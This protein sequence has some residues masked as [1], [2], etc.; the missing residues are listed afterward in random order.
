MHPKGINIFNKADGD[1][2]VV[3][4]PDHFQLQFLPSQDGF[5]HKNLSYQAGLQSS[6]TDNL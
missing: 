6:G 2:V 1:D 5:L 3:R 4:I